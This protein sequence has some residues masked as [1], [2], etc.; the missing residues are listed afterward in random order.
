MLV[1]GTS[2]YCGSGQDTI[3]LE[4][5]KIY[6]FSV[7]SMGDVFRKIA[8]EQGISSTRANLQKIRM[9]YDKKYG[10]Y[11]FPKVLSE[12]ILQTSQNAIITGI[13]TREEVDIYKSQ[14]KFFLVFVYA[15]EM[16]RCERLIKRNFPRDPKNFQ[17]FLLQS[18]REIE[19]FDIEYLRQVSDYRIACNMSLYEL[20]ENLFSVISDLDFLKLIPRR[21]NTSFDKNEPVDI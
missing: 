18:K 17:E 7:F 19:L 20:Q 5:A 8:F 3:A 11:Y 12:K 1:I 15:D 6:Q 21:A 10:R 9:E 14:F 13:R 2:A 16:V 4:L